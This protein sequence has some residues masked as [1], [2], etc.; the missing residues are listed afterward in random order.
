MPLNQQHINELKKI[1]RHD[2]GDDL[3][4][5]DAWA[6]GIRLIAMFRLLLDRSEKDKRD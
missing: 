1:Y 4:D 3:S 5:K 2:N 6:M